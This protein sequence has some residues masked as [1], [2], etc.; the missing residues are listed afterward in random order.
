MEIR[1]RIALPVSGAPSYTRSFD[2]GNAKRLY[3][4][5]HYS[6]FGDA[7]QCAPMVTVHAPGFD[8]ARHVA[9]ATTLNYPTEDRWFVRY[10]GGVT[11]R[12]R[13]SVMQPGCRSSI[14]VDVKH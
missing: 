5:M 6:T 7:V 11:G 8:N 14:S 2:V 10:Y 13:L 12:I 4:T 9:S 3:F 1:R